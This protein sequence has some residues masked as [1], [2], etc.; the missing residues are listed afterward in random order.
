MMG[1]LAT[2][3]Q[4]TTDYNYNYTTGTTPSS[5]MPAGVTA[6]L[7][8]FYLAIIVL[9]IMALWKI[10]VKAGRPGWV[11]IVPVYSSWVLFEIVGYPGWWVLLA[12]VPFV[13][14]FPAVM[15]LI[16]Y[17]KLAKLFGKSDGFAVC[18]VLFGI[19]TLPILAFGKSQF[20]GSAPAGPVPQVPVA[21]LAPVAPQPPVV[22]QAPVEFE[23]PAQPE[24]PTDTTPTP[25]QPPVV[26]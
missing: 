10:F 16:A 24:A 8:L 18:N 12:F 5:S 2:F 4:Y 26:L 14:I 9:L 7:V 6:I 17:F 25:P 23:A 19:V 15:M 22:P 13:N 1:L 11:A 21:P 20:Q 3:A